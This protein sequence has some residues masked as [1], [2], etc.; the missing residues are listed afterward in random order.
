MFWVYFNRVIFSFPGRK[1]EELSSEAFILRTGHGPGGK[2]HE[3][4]QGAPLTGPLELSHSD[5]PTL[6]FPLASGTC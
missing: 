3:K 4:E 6:R 2:M 1:H 5:F